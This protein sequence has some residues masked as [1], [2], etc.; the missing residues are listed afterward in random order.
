MKILYLITKSNWGGAQRYVFDL[1]THLPKGYEAVVAAGGD[2][3]LK[4]KLREKN[5]KVIDLPAGRDIAIFT[6]IKLIFL[7]LKIILKE[8]PDVLHVNSSKLAGL[9]AFVGFI[10][11]TR[12]IFTAHGWPFNEDRNFVARAAIY[13]FT[14]L[15]CLFSD[16]TITLARKEFSQGQMMPLVSHKMRLVYNGLEPINFLSREEARA[17][18][19]P[20][21]PSYHKRGQAEGG[22]DSEIWV[23]TISELTK[24]KGLV[25][26]A[27]AA[28]KIDNAKFVVF[29][30]GEQRSD[31]EDQ[32]QRSDL[33]SRF[34][35]L[36]LIPEAR[37]YLRA[38][39]IF[40]LTSTKEG[41]PYVL[42]EAAQAGLPV[43]ASNVGG[44]PEIVGPAGM[45]VPPKN[46][47]LIA[48]SINALVSNPKLRTDL[49]TQLRDRVTK[50]FS[51]EKFLNE[52]YRQYK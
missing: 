45:L 41:L 19:S 7:L 9:G 20:P 16:I 24:N 21:A 14:W 13:F 10:T 25:Y 48:R 4:A 52:T 29:G 46:P 40:T 5:V 32:I 39:D 37:E 49:G 26:L 51:F 34:T 1:A 50:S 27:Q 30:E 22:G 42:L 28:E 11:R 8:K 35:L 18:L 47:E 33:G 38:F 44:I 3:L 36:G 23:G 31:L 2:G 12:T 6:D 17:K 15:T 43:V